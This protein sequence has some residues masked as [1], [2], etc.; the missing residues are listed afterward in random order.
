MSARC[1]TVNRYLE[2]AGDKGNGRVSEAAVL[3]AQHLHAQPTQVWSQYTHPRIPANVTRMETQ[4]RDVCE[5]LI[6]ES[7]PVRRMQRMG[8][9]LTLRPQAPFRAMAELRRECP[10]IQKKRF[11]G[12][13]IFQ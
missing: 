13:G 8:S 10:Q 7:P 4:P 12:F 5:E 2:N 3:D 6:H 11:V 9:H 1:I